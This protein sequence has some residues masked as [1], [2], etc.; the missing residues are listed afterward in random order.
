MRFLQSLLFAFRGIKNC[1]LTEKNFR[2]QFLIGLIILIAGVYFH[3]SHTEWIII[4][5]CISL[6]LSLEMINSAIESVCNFISPSYHDGIKRI[7]DISAGAVLISSLFSIIIGCIIFFP[8]V[9]AVFI[10][11]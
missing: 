9:I 10:T 4:L 6:V 5:L 1:L 3:I 8:K 2:I 7:K 11:T